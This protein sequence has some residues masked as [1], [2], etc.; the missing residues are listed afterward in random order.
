MLLQ[1]GQKRVSSSSQGLRSRLTGTRRLL[2]WGRRRIWSRLH[3]WINERCDSVPLGRRCRRSNTII[4]WQK[5]VFLF[6]SCFCFDKFGNHHKWNLKRK[7]KQSYCIYA[8]LITFHLVLASRGGDP[9]WSESLKGHLC[10]AGGVSGCSQRRTSFNLT[11]CGPCLTC[12]AKSETVLQLHKQTEPVCVALNTVK[13]SKFWPF[14]FVGSGLGLKARLVVEAAVPS[15]SGA[16]KPKEAA[17]RTGT[18]SSWGQGI[19]SPQDGQNLKSGCSFVPH[20]GQNWKG[21]LQ[22]QAHS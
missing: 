21:I 7:R 15:F 6:S 3:Y 11:W 12:G 2:F 18:S 8:H 4:C 9:G 5:S 1:K 20:W 22:E 14:P 13:Q 10:Q 19:R 16:E 17:I